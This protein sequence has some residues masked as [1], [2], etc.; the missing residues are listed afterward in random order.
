LALAHV[1]IVPQAAHLLGE[2]AKCLFVPQ[3]EMEIKAD[4][5]PEAPCKNTLDPVYEKAWLL[6]ESDTN[7]SGDDSVHLPC[8][9][10]RSTSRATEF[11]ANGKVLGRSLW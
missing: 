11:A 6:L 3:W 7:E 1:Q 4:Q 2:K 9:R 8:A 5:L 10:G